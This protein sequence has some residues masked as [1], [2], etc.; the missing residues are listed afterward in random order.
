MKRRVRFTPAINPL[1][2]KLEQS[3]AERGLVTEWRTKLARIVIV[4]KDGRFTDAEAEAL[5]EFLG[6]CFVVARMSRRDD[7]TEFVGVASDAFVGILARR[8]RTGKW[9]ATGDEV[10]VLAGHLDALAEAIGALPETTIRIALAR[11]HQ[12][13]EAVRRQLLRARAV[14]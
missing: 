1:V 3:A 7:V 10:R 13:S 12:E 6:T 4:L 11:S 8:K 14:E 9:G 5:H 2:F